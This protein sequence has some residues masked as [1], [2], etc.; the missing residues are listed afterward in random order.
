[1]VSRP[2]DCS[3]C[4]Q[5]ETAPC[6]KGYGKRPNAFCPRTLRHLI[7]SPTSKS[8]PMELPGPATRTSDQPSV[9]PT[10]AS[11]STAKLLSLGDGVFR[12]NAKSLCALAFLPP[13]DASGAFELLEGESEGDE[14][15][16]ATCFEGT[17]I[18]HR[19]PNGGG[20][21]R[22]NFPTPYGVRTPDGATAGRGRIT[23]RRAPTAR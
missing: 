2:I 5:P 12:V 10:L 21:R 1:M 13:S 7:S 20:R 8:Q 16:L 6:T 17:Y 9:F 15:D 4:P 23:P 11:P 19:R 3:Q 14:M 22:P 18:G